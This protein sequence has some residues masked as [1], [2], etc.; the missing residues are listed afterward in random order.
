MKILYTD[1]NDQKH[2][3]D[4][5]ASIDEVCITKPE[6]PASPKLKLR[7]TADNGGIT[8]RI[9]WSATSP[10]GSLTGLSDWVIGDIR[11]SVAKLRKPFQLIECDRYVVLGDNLHRVPYNRLDT[12]ENI[13]RECCRMTSFPWWSDDIHKL[14]YQWA[15]SRLHR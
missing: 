14:F 12:L 1:N 5:V 15:V 7:Y 3:I 8:V 13:S 9:P 10:V 4:D 2:L 11:E 6:Q